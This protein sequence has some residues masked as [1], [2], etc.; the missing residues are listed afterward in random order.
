M[1]INIYARS[2]LTATRHDCVN[3]RDYSPTTALPLDM[4]TTFDPQVNRPRGFAKLAQL[5]KRLGNAVRLLQRPMHQPVR[6]I[7]LRNL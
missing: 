1:L 7:D 4:P 6:C 3:V 2:M 5:I